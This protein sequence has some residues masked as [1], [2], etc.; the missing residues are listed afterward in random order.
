MRVYK[1]ADDGGFEPFA[2]MLIETDGE[3]IMGFD[4]WL[5]ADLVERFEDERG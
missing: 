2:V 3:K 1:R 5:D 4:A